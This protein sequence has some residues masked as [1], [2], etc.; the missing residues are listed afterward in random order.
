[1]NIFGRLTT[2]TGRVAQTF[3]DSVQVDVPH[4]L[5]PKS[6]EKSSVYW[7]A[8]PLRAGRYLLEVVVKDVN[9]GRV[10]T[11]RHE[12]HV[13][14]YGDDK[15]TTSSLIVADR[16]EGVPSTE[17]GKGNFVIGNTYVRPRVPGADGKP[18]VF[19]RG[20]RIGFW[21]QVYNLGLD[22]KTHKPTAAVDFDVVNSSSGKSVMHSQQLT[23]QMGNVGDQITLQKTLPAADLQP[24]VYQLRVR[25]ND[26]VS[27]QVVEPSAAFSVE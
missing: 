10:G 13:P 12:V 3:G 27:K 16:L 14:D 24:G 9:G 25:V 5:L 21:M 15:L 17:V 6:T 23:S 2:L 4:D 26:E 22:D 18:V 19:T 1:V 8:L 20:Q 11:W 7:K